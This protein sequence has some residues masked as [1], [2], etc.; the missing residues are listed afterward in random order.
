MGRVSLMP[1][2]EIDVLTT[3]ESIRSGISEMRRKLEDYHTKRE[4]EPGQEQWGSAWFQM[5]SYV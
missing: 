4:T 5:T 3:M 1:S 2:L